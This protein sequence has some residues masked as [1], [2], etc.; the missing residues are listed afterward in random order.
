MLLII[1]SF[2]PV[3]VCVCFIFIY[4]VCLFGFGGL[5]GGGL[6][7]FLGGGVFFIFTPYLF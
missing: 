3:A 4:F 1:G 5:G 7:F 2:S 6:G